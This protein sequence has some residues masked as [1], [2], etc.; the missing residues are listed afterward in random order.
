[1]KEGTCCL[2]TY[3]LNFDDPENS[4][5][6]LEKN[7][8]YSIQ[9]SKCTEATRY[10]MLTPPNT[11][12]VPLPAETPV[13]DPTAQALGYV[14]GIV[15]MNHQLKKPEDQTTDW[16]LSYDLTNPSK[17]EN[18]YNIYEVYLRA[19]IT[20]AGKQTPKEDFELCAYEMKTYL[21]T[22]ALKEKGEG[23]VQVLLRFNYVS[24][25]EA[26]TATWS[27]SEYL[28]IDVLKIIP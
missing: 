19:T 27:Q 9:V 28:P 6:M 3:E 21:E 26:G 5:A 12:P 2:I 13:S 18:G 4:P 10:P 22:A 14:K 8:Y 17:S 25:I 20:N 7:R 24:K 15:F 23:N 16:E 1:M 11:S